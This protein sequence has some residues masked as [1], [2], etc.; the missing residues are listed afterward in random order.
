MDAVP[1]PNRFSSQS[2]AVTPDRLLCSRIID[3][4]SRVIEL[5]LESQVSQRGPVLNLRPQLSAYWRR[6]RG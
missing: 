6:R 5:L 4:Y 1:S 2:S 3:L